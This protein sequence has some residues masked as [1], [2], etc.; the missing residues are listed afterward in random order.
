MRQIH[1]QEF[2]A[3]V[4]HS[5]R[6]IASTHCGALNVSKEEAIAW[7]ER[8]TSVGRVAYDEEPP[9]I[10]NMGGGWLVVGVS[11]KAPGAIQIM[12]QRGQG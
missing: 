2:R 7:G 8:E 12:K 1:I 5:I 3:L 4:D 9:L 10:M 6:V 11:P